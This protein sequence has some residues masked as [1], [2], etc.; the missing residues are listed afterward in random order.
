M[1]FDF[2]FDCRNKDNAFTAYRWTPCFSL[3]CSTQYDLRT[4][5]MMLTLAQL[6]GVLWNILV[7]FSLKLWSS[8]QNQ[9]PIP[10]SRTNPP[11]SVSVQIVGE[12]VSVWNSAETWRKC[13]LIDVP[14]IPARAFIVGSTGNDST[15]ALS[16]NS[17]RII[18]GAVG[19]HEMHGPTLVNQ[20]R[21]CTIAWNATKDPDPSMFAGNEFI[22]STVRFE[23]GTVVAFVHT[24]KIQCRC[25]C[26]C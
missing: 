13:K 3:I 18:D 19:Y 9:Q 2:N 7:L 25:S 12:P 17:V 6:W 16:P 15:N 11:A 1:N 23:N 26:I 21:S 20:S 5:S 10:S 4:R 14:D 24:G 22:D 8:S